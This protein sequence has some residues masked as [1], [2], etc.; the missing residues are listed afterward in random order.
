[1]H[2]GIKKTYLVLFLK[3]FWWVIFL[4]C[5]INA[6][7]AVNVSGQGSFVNVSFSSLNDLNEG[8]MN[9]NVLLLGLHQMSSLSPDVLQVAKDVDVPSGLDL[10]QHGV[11]HN[12]ATRSS[13]SSA[14]NKIEV[15]IELLFSMGAYLKAQALSRWLWKLKENLEDGDKVTI[16]D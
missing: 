11:Q 14:A 15:F 2:L 10:P 3:N 12:V 13:N 8:V 9:E 4:I 16:F 5:D 6:L 1:M 7:E